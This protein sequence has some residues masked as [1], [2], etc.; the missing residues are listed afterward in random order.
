[1]TLTHDKTSEVTQEDLPVHY[2]TFRGILC[3][4]YNNTGPARHYKCHQKNKQNKNYV[5]H[6]LK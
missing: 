3:P 6:K 1:V 2:I 5:K 4:A